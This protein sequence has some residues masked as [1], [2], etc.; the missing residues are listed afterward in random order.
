MVP[1]DRTIEAGHGGTSMRERVGLIEPDRGVRPDLLRR[2]AR[3]GIHVEPYD[4]IEDFLLVR[5]RP[6]YA[7]LIS[8]ERLDASDL[9]P[10][11]I[12]HGDWRAIIAYAQRPTPPRIVEFMRGGG[13]DYLALPLDPAL[14][15]Q[16]LARLKQGRCSYAAARRR[17]AAARIRLAGLSPR[18]A[19]V[20]AS[21]ADGRS[22]KSIGKDL[23]ISPRT[24]EIHRAN[25]LGKLGA[26][27][28]TEALRMYYEDWLLNG[29]GTPP[30]G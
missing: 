21:M 16:S 2:L 17:A 3:A 1:G 12:E 18:E 30:G 23:G 11:L 28:S 19:E 9:Q 4:S 15:G 22:N 5:A 6:G 13:Y 25:M 8:D 29:A 24:V 26:H 14:L 20:L 27:S 10:T 7:V